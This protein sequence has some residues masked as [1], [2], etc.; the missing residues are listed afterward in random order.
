MYKKEV[1]V[2]IP[3]RNL[4]VLSH[5]DLVKGRLLMVEIEIEGVAFCTASVHQV[6][7]HR[8]FRVFLTSHFE[9]EKCSNDQLI[10]EGDWNWTTDFTLDRTR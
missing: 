9:L 10:L 6:Q 4:S 8:G 7:E 1:T 5:N 3:T 2:L